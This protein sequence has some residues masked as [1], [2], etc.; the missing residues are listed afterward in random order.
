M[1]RLVCLAEVPR[2]PDLELVTHG[3]RV[4]RPV[5]L[6][7]GAPDALE[8]LLDEA[9]DALVPGEDGRLLVLLDDRAAAR[10]RLLVGLVGAARELDVVPLPS[11]LPPLAV[12]V[13][14][15]Q[16]AVLLAVHAD[17]GRTL[18]ALPALAADL[19]ALAWLGS[20]GGLEHLSTGVGQHLRSWLP[21]A[22][23]LARASAPAS[24]VTT[25]D[26]TVPALLRSRP[27]R[28]VAVARALKGDDDWVRRVALPAMDPESVVEAEPAGE[29]AD[30]G[31]RWWGT[32]RCVEVVGHARDPVAA[33]ADVLPDHTC[34]WCG[35]PG[36]ADVCPLCGMALVSAG[37]A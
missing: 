15:E 3:H 14:A 18:A 29:A 19:D 22:A 30:P 2:L 24:V 9:D 1:T 17:D 31:A 4:R 10:A 11:R 34:T 32:A 21:G 26:E 16:L 35:Q 5:V 23:F 8:A 25:T 20:V 27:G 12:A 6:D 36:S 7:P 37:R 33:V 28:G 13:L